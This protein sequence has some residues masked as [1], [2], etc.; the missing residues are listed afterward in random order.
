[1]SP[2]L[3][4]LAEEA[5]PALVGPD[6]VG[7]LDRLEQ[8]HDNLRA[9]LRWSAERGDVEREARLCAALWRF[10]YYHGHLIEGERWLADALAR[11]DADPVPR[12]CVGRYCRPPAH[13]PGSEENWRTPRHGPARRWPSSKQPV[14]GSAS[15]PHSIPSGSWPRCGESTSVAAGSTMQEAL[16]LRSNSGT[17]RAPRTR[18]RSLGNL[19]RE[20][21]RLDHATRLFDHSLALQRQSGNKRGIAI[22][23]ASLANIALDRGD[24][25]LSETLSVQSLR[26][27]RG[28]VTR[29]C[30]Y[31]PC[32]TSAMPCC[33][34]AMPSERWQSRPSACGWPATLGTS[35]ASRW[36]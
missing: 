28:W 21:G 31:L 34:R 27:Y 10:W 19:A 11:G 22:A 36:D 24:F 14:I 29:H 18:W 9:A 5:E 15:P 17:G 2:T 30:V 33:T 13:W 35:G 26:L 12:S 1:M 32:R 6:Q 4:A 20:Q 7:W 16:R 25:A 3:Y 8:E 23:L